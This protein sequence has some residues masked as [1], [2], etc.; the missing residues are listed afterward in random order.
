MSDKEKK[1]EKA[2]KVAD[3]VA[4][5]IDVASQQMIRR[6]QELNI[7][8]AFDRAVAMK[9]CNIGNQGTCCKNCGMGPCRLPLP[10]GL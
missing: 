7:D 10:K 8:T 5:T 6:A 1:V 3:P 4:A 9:P 2:K